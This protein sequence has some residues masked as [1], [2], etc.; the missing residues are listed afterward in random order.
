MEDKT[1]EAMQESSEK[2]EKKKGIFPDLLNNEKALSFIVILGLV[3]IAL[4]FIS[5]YIR[6]P[7][8]DSEETVE[9]SNV[10]FSELATY[11]DE[12]SEELGNMLASMDGVGRTKVMV[13]IDGTSRNIYA[14]DVDVNDRETSRKSGTDENA[15]KQN[16]EKKSCIVIKQKDGS[17]KALTVGQLMPEIKG[18]LVICDGGDDE[19]VCK[20]ITKAV[21]AALNISESHI[22]VTKLHS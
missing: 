17:E 18:V 3:G 6:P 7:S 20:N 4:I 2:E 9:E 5:S 19:S 15:D 12:I 10:S 1:T 14:T 16:T 21:S 8:D 11:R 22:C 13:T